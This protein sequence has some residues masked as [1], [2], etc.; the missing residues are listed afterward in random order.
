MGLEAA[1]QNYVGTAALVGWQEQ[2]ARSQKKHCSMVPSS[3]PKHYQFISFSS[4]N[5]KDTGTMKYTVPSR[6]PVSPFPSQFMNFGSTY[7]EAQQGARALVW[8]RGRRRRAHWAGA[9]PLGLGRGCR[10][11]SPEGLL[12]RPSAL[13]GLGGAVWLFLPRSGHSPLRPLLGLAVAAVLCRQC[14]PRAWVCRRAG[15]GSGRHYRAAICA[16]LKK[17]LTIE[18]VDPRP[19]GLTRS[20]L[21][22]ISVEL[23]LVIF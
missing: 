8:A 4:E 22:S 7:R 5:H 6:T 10:G 15:Q 12:G 2:E 11:S 21:M 20:G 14:F 16:E 1:A 18:E 3:E 23:T 13:P 17:T 19:V 9:A